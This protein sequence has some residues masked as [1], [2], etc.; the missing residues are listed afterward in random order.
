MSTPGNPVEVTDIE[1]FRLAGTKRTWREALRTLGLAATSDNIAAF[2]RRAAA[3]CVDISGVKMR[4]LMT[5]IGTE[6]LR[7]A[8]EGAKTFAEVLRR[9]DL[10]VGGSTYKSLAEVCARRSVQLPPAPCARKPADRGGRGRCS[11][12]RIIAAYADARSMA[13]LLR[14]LGLAPEGG[15]YRWMESRLEQL[16]LDAGDLRTRGRTWSRGQRTGPRRTL[17]S[18]LQPNTRCSGS[19][20]AKRLVE[21]QL[22]YDLCYGCL[23]MTWCGQPIPLELDHING[24]STDN[25]L[26]NLRLLCPNCH[27]LTP[28][29]RGRNI[30]RN[31]KVVT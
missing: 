8:A 22:L 17:E 12:E 1:L 21:A 11:D 18:Y 23:G 15:N 7:R 9:L 6:E 3:E 31:R 25:R 27:A 10:E 26:A 29:Y 2:K 24:D 14:R 16:G 4:R 13:D 28:T 19:W 20:L 30:G 5:D